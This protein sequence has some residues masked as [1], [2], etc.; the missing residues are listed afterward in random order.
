MSRSYI[1]SGMGLSQWPVILAVQ[2]AAL[3]EDADA[4][5]IIGRT[6]SN[7]FQAYGQR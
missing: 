2:V 7:I 4:E 6:D 1:T 3:V 5:R